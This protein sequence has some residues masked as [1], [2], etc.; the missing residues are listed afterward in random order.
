METVHILDST[1]TLSPA[2]S[3]TMTHPDVALEALRQIIADFADF[4]RVHGS[5]SEADTRAKV[6][7]RVLREVCLWPEQ[8]IVR[9]EHVD[10]GYIDY[11]LQLNSKAVVAVE[12]KREGLPFT[13]PVDGG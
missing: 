4:C 1:S 11:Y 13:M 9:E 3:A 2:D 8:D 12:A 10:R 5:V 6:I 7:D